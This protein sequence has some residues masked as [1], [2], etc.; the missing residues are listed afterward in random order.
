V[1]LGLLFALTALADDEPVSLDSVDTG[2]TLD[3]DNLDTGKTHSLDTFDKG[4]TVDQDTL[5]VGHTNTLDSADKGK[6]VDQDSIDTGTT[7]SL[8]DAETAP[9]APP[10]QP[11][12]LP[13][14]GDDWLREKAQAAHDALVDAAYRAKAADAAYSEMRAH[15]FP[16]GEEAAAIVKEYETSRALYDQA[17]TKYDEILG[18]VDPAAL[19]N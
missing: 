16:R 12:P 4:K 15:D 18:Q 7:E 11:A 19:G 13:P 17:Q 5:D 2:S 8:S 6:T 10:S 14:M 1:I 3:Q 9:A